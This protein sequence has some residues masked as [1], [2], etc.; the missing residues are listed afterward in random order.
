MK[1]LFG[2]IVVIA[3]IF[4]GYLFMNITGSEEATPIS[5]AESNV[6]VVDGTQIIT[7][8]AK[9]GYTPKVTVAQSGM[10]TI[11]RVTT[12]GT[13]DCSSALRIPSFKVSRTLPMNG[14]TDIPLGTLESGVIQGNCGMGMYPFQINV[15][16]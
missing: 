3:L 16:N 4:G 7:L 6:S 14:T 10:P 12:N 11:L 1:I 13:F 9:G 15:E 8:R 5:Q 2:L